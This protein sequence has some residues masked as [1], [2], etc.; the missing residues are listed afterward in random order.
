MTSLFNDKN[1]NDNIILIIKGIFDK[2]KSWAKVMC[3]SRV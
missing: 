2:I 3:N 1:V